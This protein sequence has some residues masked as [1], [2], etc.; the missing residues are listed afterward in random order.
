MPWETG[1]SR[2]TAH[3]GDPEYSGTSH[4]RSSRSL[5]RLPC[6]VSQQPQAAA[7]RMSAENFD[8][9]TWAEARPRL[10]RRIT[11]LNGDYN[12]TRTRAYLQSIVAVEEGRIMM[13]VDSAVPQLGTRR[14]LRTTGSQSTGMSSTRSAPEKGGVA[15]EFTPVSSSTRDTRLTLAC[16]LQVGPRRVSA[17]PNHG[18]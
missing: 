18:G 6:R 15:L 9:I 13:N 3:T 17:S 16:A 10:V 12:T 4:G 11:G 5:G 8:P 7:S 2:H 1:C 14:R